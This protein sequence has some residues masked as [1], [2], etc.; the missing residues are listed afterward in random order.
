MNRKPVRYFVLLA[1]LATDSAPARAL[2]VVVTIAPIHSLVAAVTRGV[3]EPA[4]L[5][6]PGAT[7]HSYALRPSDIKRLRDADMVV[8]VGAGL[9]RFLDKTLQALPQSIRLIVLANTP[10]VTLLRADV[11][12]DHGGDHDADPH[13]WLD[14]VNAKFIVSYL[15]HEFSRADPA[16]AA[17]YN[18]N[19]TETLARLEQLDLSVRQRLAPVA[20]VPY[21]VFHDAYRY[22]EMRYGLSQA[23]AFTMDPTRPPGAR[24]VREMRKRLEASGTRCIFVEPQFRP[25]LLRSVANDTGASIGVLDPVGAGIAPGPNAYFLLIERMAQALSACLA[26]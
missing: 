10:G 23:G 14:P 18:S 21:I 26:R 24:R 15:A 12:R 6:P 3:T 2:E 13:L 25:A 19:E 1:A 17:S 11:N 20:E 8:S 22:F 4:L 5:L 9:E 16:N 7:P